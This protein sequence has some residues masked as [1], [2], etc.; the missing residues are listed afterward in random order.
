[1]FGRLIVIAVL[2]ALPCG[3]AAAQEAIGTV[4]R[5]QGEA[6]GILG[7]TTLP[8][9]ANGSSFSTRSFRP[10]M[11]RGLKSLSPTARGSR[12]EKRPS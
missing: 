4:S 10:A 3:D 12:S 1:M 8:L 9:S 6:S 2:L 5:L 11:R 7:G